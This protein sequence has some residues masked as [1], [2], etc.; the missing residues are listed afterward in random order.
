MD[1]KVALVLEGGGFRGLYTAGILHSFSD[2]ELEF[3]YVIAVSMGASNATNYL[4]KQTIRNIEVPYTF[5]TDKRYISYTR[6]FT[7]GELFGMTFIF[8]DIPNKHIPFDFNTF[9]ASKQKL[10]YVTTDCNSGKPYFISNEITEDA[11]KALEASTSLPFAAKMVKLHDRLLLDGGIS[12]P[13]P[14]DKALADGAEKL[15]VILTQPKG[16]RKEPFKAKLIAK[17]KYKN[18]PLL[19]ESI[20][21][22]HEVYNRQLA[23][24]EKL[25]ATG[26]AFVIRPTR[27][28]AINRT[29]KNR[30]KLKEAFDIGHQQGAET[31]PELLKFIK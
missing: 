5:V 18:Y 23:L 12:D 20:L 14:V 22:R 26:K 19:V 4:S 7:K 15:V 1:K 17:L 24:I 10:I 3:P 30:D 21:N 27:K 2:Y 29:E 28:L 8:N 16:Y 9:K 11:F 31:M 13:I 6:L 25:E